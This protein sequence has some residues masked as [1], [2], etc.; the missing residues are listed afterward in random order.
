MA[1]RYYLY[2]RKR[3]GKPSI[4]YVRFRAEDG[5]IS[6][7]I[8]TGQS[9]EKAA[10]S[11]AVERLLGGETVRARK[12]RVLTFKE[13]AAPWWKFDSCPYIREKVAGGFTISRAYAEVRRSYLDRHLVPEFGN[14]PLSQLS[15]RHFRDFK[16]KLYQEGK[17]S[18]ATIN[19]ILGTARVMFNYA[20]S[21]GELESNP[22]APVKELK[23]TPQQRGILTADELR[24][25]FGSDT[26][27][28]AWR[29]DQKHFALN[30]LAASTGMRLGEIQALQMKYLHPEYIEVRHSWHDRYGLSAPK[31]GSART[32]PVP[33]RTAEALSALIAFKRWGEPQPSDIVF[34]GQSRDIPLTK[35]AILKQFKAALARIGIKEDERKR[36]VLLFHGYRH[37]FNT[38]VRG[39]VPDEQLRRVTGHKT[40]AMSDN[41]DHAALEHLADVKAAQEKMFAEK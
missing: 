37:G 8:S 18:P 14:V 39:K 30:I 16:M 2:E 20:V 5:T 17:L 6:S 1:K 27:D 12:P 23:E 11:W 3:S 28:K 15:P 33:T 10:E 9:G 29:S 32:V 22:V 34:W 31:W 26:H 7:P 41:Y 35:T 4:W 19:R 36:R 24:L 21:M 13:W 40:L 38:F 25:L